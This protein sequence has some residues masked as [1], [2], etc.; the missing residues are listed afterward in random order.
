[1]PRTACAGL[2]DSWRPTVSGG[3][4]KGDNMTIAELDKI[5]SLLAEGIRPNKEEV[6]EL[7]AL[8]RGK[9]HERKTVKG[10]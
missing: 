1:M 6:D 9:S 4:S 7:L 5:A 8:A 10:N 2:D 3:N